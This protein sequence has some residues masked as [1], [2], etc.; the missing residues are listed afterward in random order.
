LHAH[1]E[2][3]GGISRYTADD[4]RGTGHAE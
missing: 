4:T 3:V 2:H 1:V